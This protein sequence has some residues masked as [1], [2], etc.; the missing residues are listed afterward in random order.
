[1]MNEN[2][3]VIKNEKQ[4]SRSR[5]DIYPPTRFESVPKHY[6][7][8]V[9][10]RTSAWGIGGDES[11]MSLLGAFEDAKDALIFARTMEARLQN[12]MPLSSTPTYAKK[13]WFKRGNR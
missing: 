9:I 1:M 7:Y 11:G 13:G 8:L 4:T 10:Y 3:I 2:I 12:G 5:Y 6:K